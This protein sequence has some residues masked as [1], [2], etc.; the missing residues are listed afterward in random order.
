MGLLTLL[1]VLGFGVT[2]ARVGR[3]SPATAMF[4]VTA[5]IILSLYVGALAGVLW[6]V[7]LA[8]HLAGA[9][10]LGLEAL[11][12]A[13]TGRN[14]IVPVPIGLLLLMAA[15]FWLLHD[16]QQY[17]MYDEYSHWGIFLKE[18]L[19]LDGFWL[20]DT[21]SMHPRYPPA[22]TLWQ[23]LFNALGV[24]TEGKAYLAQFVLLV[25]PLL[26]LWN[27]LMWRQLLWIS[28]IAAL[29]VLAL[30]NYGL[31]VVSLYVDPVISTWFAGVILA[32]ML[33]PQHGWLRR[34]LQSAAP[35][36]V[37]AL[38]KD[39]ALGFALAAGGTIATLLFVS[40]WR[41]SHGFGR[42]FRQGCF[43]LLLM[44][45]AAVLSIQIWTW[46]RDVAGSSEEV[47]SFEGII[48]GIHEGSSGDTA[49]QT[50]LARRFSEVV[51]TQQLS[52][53]AVAWQFN[54]FT[55]GIRSLF[56]EPFRLTTSAAFI[57]F[58]V[59]STA[60]MVIIARGSERWIWSTAAI[61]VLLTAAAYLLV[62]YLSY[63]FVFG[64]RGLNLPSYV[65]YANTVV[66]PMIL[67]AFA[68]LVPAFAGRNQPPSRL[69]D[70]RLKPGLFMAGLLALWVFEFPYLR[71]LVAGHP[72]NELRE[73]LEPVATTLHQELGRESLWIYIPQDSGNDFVGRV[74]Q[75]LL[76]PTPAT[77]ERSMSYFERDPATLA[78]VFQRFSYVWIPAALPPEVSSRVSP[79][80]H[81]VTQGL[82]FVTAGGRELMPITH[83]AGERDAFS[84]DPRG[85]G[86]Q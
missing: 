50:D 79:I 28:S 57:L 20:A 65:R 24:P 86:P 64:E 68:P 67:F 12:I 82:F 7:T 35:I 51:Q 77:V 42:A 56:T 23:Y 73:A 11:R 81:G 1:I 4:Q 84:D 85:N 49:R 36:A 80:T 66:L 41:E 53:D 60:L 14:A 52:N 34:A 13:R 61:G 31:G 19:A 25:A 37:I 8:I 30:A 45:G 16:D 78:A 58:A 44:G 6:W 59:W 75:Y 15:L 69:L 5:I 10:M 62:L 71:P 46:N 38:L 76:S 3:M 27:G 63:P 74:M 2:A 40:T 70:S 48:Q 43:S 21:N 54:E 17:F 83:S 29:C 22:A 18:M 26:V 47:A 33:D 32:H 39:G 72:K 9:V 55:Y